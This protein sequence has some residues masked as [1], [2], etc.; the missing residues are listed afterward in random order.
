MD[1]I[2]SALVSFFLIA[3][4]EEGVT[5]ALVA[6]GV[7]EAVVGK[8]SACAKTAAPVIVK[9]ATGEPAWLVS[10]VY[11]LW[12]GSKRPDAILIEAA[13]ACAEPVAAARAHFATK[14]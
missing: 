7:P 10:S 6:A 4:L 5:R 9:R 14:T 13:P 8:V 12:T 11:S 3:P 2:I 1:T